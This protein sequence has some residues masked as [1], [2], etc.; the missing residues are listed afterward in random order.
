MKAS[1]YLIIL[2]AGLLNCPTAHAQS[3]PQPQTVMPRPEDGGGKGVDTKKVYDIV[4][5][6]PTLPNGSRF[7]SIPAAVQQAVV[8]PAGV[9]V[10]ERVF[11]EFVV[12]RTGRVRDAKILKASSPAV[13][14]A[15]L[16][17]V[18]KLPQ[19]KPGMQNGETTN[20]RL[21]LPVSLGPRP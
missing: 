6:M 4:E 18:A 3:L 8:V 14:K 15:V 16:A 9:A 12:D 19:L 2:A 10:E 11:V 1:L 13:G 5:Q 17:A 7:G 21:R 20:V